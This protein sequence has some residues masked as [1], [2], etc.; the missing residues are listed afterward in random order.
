[1]KDDKSK[2]YYRPPPCPAYD[3][4]G[5]ESW[6]ESMAE[7]GYFLTSDGFFLGFGIFERR[8]PA[9]VRYRLQSSMSPG[10]LYDDNA[11]DDEAV[12][13]SQALGWRYIAN[14]GRF[15]I[16]TSQDIQAAELNTDPQVQALALDI[17]RKRERG[18]LLLTMLWLA[19]CPIVWIRFK[20]FTGAIAIG[21]VL[22]L[23]GALLVLWAICAS[24]AKVLHLHRLKKR[25]SAG[26]ALDHKKNWQTRATRYRV[27]NILF[28]VLIIAWFAVFMYRWGHSTDGRMKLE[29]YSGEL[30]F[31]TIAD[32]A[33]GGEF[34]LRDFGSY[35][36]M[37]DISSDLLAPTIISMF[38]TASV[39]L[40]D[41]TLLD[42]GLDVEYFETVS[43]WIARQIAR[44]LQSQDKSDY[45]DSYALLETPDLNADYAVAYESLF[46]TL[47]LVDGN[48]VIRI[49]FYQTSNNYTMPTQ[50]WMQIFAGHFAN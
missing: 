45:R 44:E 27:G 7:R 30:P 1:M 4:E 8:T 20:I 48:R 16:F 19:V 40:D 29:D 13:I 34:S 42:G 17:V 36:N 24:F 35:S 18:D 31:A 2:L 41:G 25:L 23:Y 6:L 47:I 28:L 38:Q 39:R 15:Y 11:P 32:L 14:R 49:A 33:P 3:I 37:I 21:T 43:P 50:E 46:T 12:E 22:S 10:G 9:R 26:G 5:T